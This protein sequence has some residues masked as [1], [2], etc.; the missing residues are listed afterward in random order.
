MGVILRLLSGPLES[1][2][3]LLLTLGRGD[4]G[5]GRTLIV[6]E[7][8]ADVGRLRALLVREEGRAVVSPPIFS[9]VGL[10]ASLVNAGGR[11]YRWLGAADKE[12]LVWELLSSAVATGRI[13]RLTAVAACN[14]TPKAIAEA[15]TRIRQSA[16]DTAAAARLLAEAGEVE[17]ELGLLLMEYERAL[18]R[19]SLI[20]TEEALLV[21]G[22]ALTDGA[23]PLSAVTR[24]LTFGSTGLSVSGLR[25]LRALS[26]GGREREVVV[27]VPYAANLAFR[28][29]KERLLTVAALVGRV[30]VDL[31]DG[32]GDTVTDIPVADVRGAAAEGI[33]LFAG[34]LSRAT[35]E[36]R[37]LAA[38]S[39]R[40][41]V[42][43]VAASI[44]RL[45]EAGISPAEV[46]VIVPEPA[47]YRPIIDDVF[48]K[49]GISVPPRQVSA[50]QAHSVAGVLALLEL[51]LLDWP[52]RQTLEALA[53]GPW[54]L[55]PRE[56]WHLDRQSRSAGVNKGWEDWAG[57]F[58]GE[59]NTG[60]AAPSVLQRLKEGLEVARRQVTVSA[61]AREVLKLLRDQKAFFRLAGRYRHLPAEGPRRESLLE[62]YALEVG[63]WQELERCLEEL[64][65]DPPWAGSTRGSGAVAGGPGKAVDSAAYQDFLVLLRSSL[66][67]RVLRVGRASHDQPRIL[68]AR[69]VSPN[70]L[71]GVRAAFVLGLVDGEFPRSR[72]ATWVWGRVADQALKKGVAGEEPD[73][74]DEDKVMLLNVL[75]AAPEYLS[76]SYPYL[77][78][79]EKEILVAPLLEQIREAVSVAGLVANDSRLEPGVE[80]ERPND[81]YPS[82]APRWQ[83]PSGEDVRAIL[84]AESLSLLGRRYE[85]GF[86]FS[87]SRLGDYGRCP[88]FYF[89]RHEL[90]LE[91]LE[92]AG[93]DVSPLE[94]GELYHEVLWRFFSAQR[95]RA[96]E[97]SS[98]SRYREEMARHVRDVAS[99]MAGPKP[100]TLREAWNARVREAERV[101]FDLIDAEIA[102]SEKAGGTTPLFCELAFGLNAGRGE[103]CDPAST[104]QPLVI[105]DTGGKEIALAG[106]IDRIDIGDGGVFVIYDYKSGSGRGDPHPLDACLAG[107]D[108]QLPV[109]LL[110]AQSLF[111]EHLGGKQAGGAAFYRLPTA[112]RTEGIWHERARGIVNLGRR[113]KGILPEKEWE[114]LLRTAAE[115]MGTYA[116]DIE[117]GRF[118]ARPKLCREECPYRPLCGRQ[119]V[120]GGGDRADV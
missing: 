77:D 108:F 27:L 20:D 117:A 44:E 103:R 31:S 99:K 47:V 21:G 10:A 112:A 73:P 59:A 57:F 39:R 46:A 19:H 113:R 23:A 60:F 17:G 2:E 9:L 41:E 13:K 16:I 88:F 90:R 18:K 93:A 82:G 42:T 97:S 33:A 68:H 14:G 118:A 76:F 62:S 120:N 8:G 34:L 104:L 37:I 4:D 85:S 3:D 91:G 43:E 102:D 83:A 64:A 81:G 45:R 54:G 48:P 71:V 67:E 32:D 24:V 40:R 66:G 29:A 52:R 26:E 35:P 92:D 6:A 95:G 80:W 109:Y 105:R 49:A 79:E 63:G 119:A 61:V 28:G 106:K 12:R 114:A 116:A 11:P 56:V 38:P 7:N 15:I 110:A 86:R 22:R 72:V 87:A 115:W 84:G 5:A 107:I 94:M 53:E 69:S 78:A 25:F 30:E 51:P 89:C 74:A 100:A 111:P 1:A 36:V 58:R 70:S 50:N 65:V 98:R 96:L 101:L 75:R 55:P